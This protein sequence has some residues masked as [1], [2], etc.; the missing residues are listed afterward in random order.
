MLDDHFSAASPLD[1]FSR[2]IVLMEPDRCLSWPWLGHV[3]FAFWVVDAVRPGVLV[4]LGTHTGT[5]YL[6]FCQAVREL[7][8]PA[9]C[10]AVDTWRGDPQSGFYGEEVYTDLQLYHE[11]RYGDFSRLVRSTF[12]DALDH[13][14]DQSVDLL[15]IDGYHVYDQLRHDFESWLPKL[16]RRGVVLFHD[17]NVREA[18][19]GAWRVWEEVSAAYP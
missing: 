10:F 5:S 19:F 17:I 18:D 6:A 2:P 4:E 13:F 12:D 1:V 7:H 8:L 14:A 9:A 16:S 15:H 3:P 11:P